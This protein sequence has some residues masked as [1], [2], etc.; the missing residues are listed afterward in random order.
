VMARLS[1]PEWVFPH[2]WQSLMYLPGAYP[3]F[4]RRAIVSAGN[5]SGRIPLPVGCQRH[6]PQPTPSHQQLSGLVAHTVTDVAGEDRR[7][8][9]ASLCCPGSQQAKRALG[10]RPL[11][12]QQRV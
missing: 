12:P 10:P 2:L 4:L 1:I 3:H 9:P 6:P 11:G 5:G 8:L 7:K